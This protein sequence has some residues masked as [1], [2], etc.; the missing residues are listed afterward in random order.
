MENEVQNLAPP[1]QK[2]LRALSCGYTKNDVKLLAE[3]TV[4]DMVKV[5]SAMAEGTSADTLWEELKNTLVKR[6][7][8]MGMPLDDDE[9]PQEAPRVEKRKKEYL[10]ATLAYRGEHFGMTCALLDDDVVITE[11]M[12]LSPAER[13][14][15]VVG[16]CLC[17]A[18]GKPIRKPMDL[19]EQIKLVHQGGALSLSICVYRD[20]HEATAAAEAIRQEELEA[21]RVQQEKNEKKERKKEK[22]LKR[23]KELEEQQQQ[24]QQQEEEQRFEEEA[25]VEPEENKSKGENAKNEDEAEKKPKR[26]KKKKKKK[27][28]GGEENVEGAHPFG[29]IP[30]E[31]EPEK[32][33]PVSVEE[34]SVSVEEAPVSAEE[35]AT[36]H[37]V[38][39]VNNHPLRAGTDQGSACALDELQDGETEKVLSMEDAMRNFRVD[40]S[41]LRS[42]PILMN[43]SAGPLSLPSSFNSAGVNELA[44]EQNEEE[45]MEQMEQEDCTPQDKRYH[46]TVPGPDP[47]PAPG[48]EEENN[49][50]DDLPAPKAPPELKVKH[51]KSKDVDG[52]EMTG[53]EEE[54]EEQEVEEREQEEEEEEEAAEEEREEESEETT[55]EEEVQEEEKQ[56][57]AFD[58]VT[59]VEV[60][61]V[62][63]KDGVTVYKVTVEGA[64]WG[65]GVWKR[66]SSFLDLKKAFGFLAKSLPPFPKKQLTKLSQKQKEARRANLSSYL[67]SLAKQ[68]LALYKSVPQQALRPFYEFIEIEPPRVQN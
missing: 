17:K 30:Y 42:Q 28:E 14:G 26:E 12:S 10:N 53:Q 32:D 59:R 64:G 66:F 60:D 46:L 8:D 20:L 7:G 38:E 31:P 61:A 35:I 49:S 51:K 34:V 9:E 50:D 62:E 33:V 55:E 5:Y 65:Y 45:P 48:V 23:A 41:S 43:P 39:E 36:R 52:I 29:F 24:Q 56:K 4:R 37:P 11:V 57:H 16:H 63:E 13:G 58:G 40:R 54:E 21:E 19:I 25:E 15:V 2:M 47:A 27:R 3:A 22:K 6:R 67:S 1:L 68:A 44:G 18:G